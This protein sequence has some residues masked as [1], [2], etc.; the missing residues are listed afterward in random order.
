MN[1]HLSKQHRSP[2]QDEDTLREKYVEEEKKAAEVADELRCSRSTIEN[3]LDEFGIDTHYERMEKPWLDREIL[4]EEY[5]VKDRSRHALAEE[6][7]CKPGTVREYVKEYG[8]AKRYVTYPK[9]VTSRGGYCKFVCDRDKREEVSMHQL[10]AIAEGADPHK[11]FSGGW[12]NVHHKNRIPWDNR[13]DNIEFLHKSE[14]ARLH[15]MERERR[16]NGQLI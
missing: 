15:V 4:R 2:W 9:L 13:P 3:W 8:L 1:V 6:W 12:Y 11:V 7:G 16:P 10:L 14:H 5:V